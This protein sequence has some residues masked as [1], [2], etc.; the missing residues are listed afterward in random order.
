[1]NFDLIFTVISQ[2][3][4]GDG[5]YGLVLFSVLFQED[6]YPNKEY[7]SIEHP[8]IVLASPNSSTE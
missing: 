1:M 8:L 6:H 4:N 5:L 7:R 3:S 2:T